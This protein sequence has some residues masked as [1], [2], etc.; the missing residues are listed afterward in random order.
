V[1]P[2]V[3]FHKLAHKAIDRS[4]GRSKTLEHI[5]ARRIFIEATEHGFELA[6]DFLRSVN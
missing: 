1:I 5:R 4:T 2:N 6:D 3:V